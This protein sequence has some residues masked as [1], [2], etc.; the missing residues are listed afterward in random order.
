MKN[1]YSKELEPE[2]FR[3]YELGVSDALYEVS[4]S[5]LACK[6][7]IWQRIGHYYSRCS[8]CGNSQS[9]YTQAPYCPVCK[10]KMTWFK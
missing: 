9:Y 5:K 8:N 1:P 3:A 7:A 10:S 2:L 4:E 6:V